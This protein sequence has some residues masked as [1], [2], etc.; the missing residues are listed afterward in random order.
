MDDEAM[1]IM[2]PKGQARKWG[3]PDGELCGFKK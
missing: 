1:E 3:P 2:E